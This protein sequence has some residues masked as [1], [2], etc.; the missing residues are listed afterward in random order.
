MRG[1]DLVN[2][3]SVL[4]QYKLNNYNK[5]WRHIVLSDKINVNFIFLENIGAEKDK[6]L[7]KYDKL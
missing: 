3:R 4:K 1:I 6:S 2:L 5:M 7:Y